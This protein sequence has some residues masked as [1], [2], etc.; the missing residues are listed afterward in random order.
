MQRSILA[1][2]SLLAFNAAA[3]QTVP[4]SQPQIALRPG[5]VAEVRATEIERYA[6][7]AGHRLVVSRTHGGARVPTARVELRCIPG[8][9]Q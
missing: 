5:R 7:T 8:A 1:L 9:P 6:C 4:T 2:A 3:Q